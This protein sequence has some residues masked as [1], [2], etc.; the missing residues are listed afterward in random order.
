MYSN[1]PASVIER[2]ERPGRQRDGAERAERGAAGR[3]QDRDD[4]RARAVEQKQHADRWNVGDEV[5]V[6]LQVH[7]ADD[8]R[9]ERAEVAQQV[10][11]RT[12]HLT[13]TVPVM[14]G[15]SWQ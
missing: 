10:R 9:R 8:D 11:A 1:S 7:D 6:L 5:G 2:D 13:I 12:A 3:Q 15:C 4:A 14:N